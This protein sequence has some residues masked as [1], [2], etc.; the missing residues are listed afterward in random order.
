MIPANRRLYYQGRNVYIVVKR[1]VSRTNPDLPDY[2]TSVNVHEHKLTRPGVRNTEHSLR[3]K[4]LKDLPARTKVCLLKHCFIFT[5]IPCGFLC[6]VYE[7]YHAIVKTPVWNTFSPYRTHWN[8]IY[9]PLWS[10]V[11]QISV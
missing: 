2:N 4:G 8:L 5:F 7:Y 11:K 10:I 9:Y 1:F 3:W 6:S